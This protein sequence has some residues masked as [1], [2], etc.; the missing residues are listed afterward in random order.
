MGLELT[1]SENVELRGRKTG[2]GGEGGLDIG[3]D[4]IFLVD[5][6]DIVQSEKVVDGRVNLPSAGHRQ[7]L[8]P[9]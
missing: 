9:F 2:S 4:D 8:D 3:V 7:K 5:K 1:Q 6:A